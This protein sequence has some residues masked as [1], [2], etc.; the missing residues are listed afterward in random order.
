[1][2]STRAVLLALAL[3]GQKTWEMPMPRPLYPKERLREKRLDV[4]LSPDELSAIQAKAADAGLRLAE[5]A[6]AAALGVKVQAVSEINAA[7]WSELAATCSNLNQLAKAANEGRVVNIPPD[8]LL[9]LL[10]QVQAFRKALL[11]VDD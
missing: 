8:L 7:R 6:R 3:R 10:D 2:Q 9:E 11:G 4:Y 1:M 5:F